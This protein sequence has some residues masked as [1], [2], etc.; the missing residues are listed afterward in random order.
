MITEINRESKTSLPQEEVKLI[1]L[2]EETTAF[3]ELEE[4]MSTTA[5]SKTTLLFE[6]TIETEVEKP[7]LTTTVPTTTV[8]ATT[9]P[10]TTTTTT[11]TITTTTTTTVMPTTIPT[12]TATTKTTVPK[13]I[14][15]QPGN[16]TLKVINEEIHSMANCPDVDCEFGYK[17]DLYGK[18]LCACYNPCWVIN[19]DQLSRGVILIDSRLRK[20][21][22]VLKFA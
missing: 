6:T 19:C 20:Q 15:V 9:I 21:N 17:T 8:P 2:N 5:S 12:T 18:T 11:I 22:V 13:F 16:K 14:L 1:K 4:I 7:I 10:T 3:V